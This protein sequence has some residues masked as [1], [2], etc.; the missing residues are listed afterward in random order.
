[1]VNFDVLENIYGNNTDHR[2]DSLKKMAAFIV[3]QICLHISK[4]RTP[5]KQVLSKAKLKICS[6][7]V[8]KAACITII[9]LHPA[10]ARL[11]YLQ[12]SLGATKSHKSRDQ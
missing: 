9:D 6:S 5:Q 8:L 12:C 7:Y 11:F 4:N 2:E 10:K 1:M 3:V